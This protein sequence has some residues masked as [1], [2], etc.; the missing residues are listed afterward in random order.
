MPDSP[1]V[2]LEKAGDIGIVIVN[3]PPVNALG[4]GV[5]EGISKA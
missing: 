4:P 5:A 2:R 3:Y 1:V